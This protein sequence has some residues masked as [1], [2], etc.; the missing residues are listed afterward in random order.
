VDADQHADGG[1]AEDQTRSTVAHERQWETV[2]RQ[3][4]RGDS[5][6]LDRRHHDDAGQAKRHAPVE[7]VV[8]LERDPAAADGDQH[9]ASHRAQGEGQ[10]ESGFRGQ[11]LDFNV[12]A[13]VLGF[14]DFGTCPRVRTLRAMR[15]VREITM[16]GRRG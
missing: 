4:R 1:K 14:Q 2:I 3:Y 9:V 10:P 16:E 6:I 8:C 13:S 5:D 15:G 12:S 11:S 7:N